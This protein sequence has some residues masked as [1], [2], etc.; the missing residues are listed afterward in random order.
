MARL[1]RQERYELGRRRLQ[2][3]LSRHVVACA[4]TIE[5]KISDA[6]PADQRIEPHVLTSVRRS[7]E[8]DGI[9]K[10]QKGAGIDWYYLA[11][12]DP[13]VVPLASIGRLSFGGGL[14][15]DR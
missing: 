3:L 7:L 10:S 1:S 4:R 12:T 8:S 9:I 5:Q 2:R 14:A 6:G 15:K 13:P 11:E